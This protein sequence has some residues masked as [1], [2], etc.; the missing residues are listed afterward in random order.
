MPFASQAQRSFM[1]A[2]HP[3]IAKRWSA[4]YPNQGRLPQ[5][6]GSKPS[7]RDVLARRKLAKPR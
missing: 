5:R 4:E 1:Y 6:V 7:V 2:E 3:A